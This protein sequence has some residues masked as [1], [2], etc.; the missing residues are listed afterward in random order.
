MSTNCSQCKKL[1]SLLAGE[2]ALRSALLDEL[3]LVKTKNRKLSRIWSLLKKR[4]K[5]NPRIVRES[6]LRQ[7]KEIELSYSGE[8]IP[9]EEVQGMMEELECGKDCMQQRRRRWVDYG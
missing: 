3:K 6:A 5:T 7:M 4:L 8:L 2:H 9:V 1:T